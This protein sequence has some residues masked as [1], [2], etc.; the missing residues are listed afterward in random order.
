MKT[1]ELKQ[2]IEWDNLTH[3]EK[4]IEAQFFQMEEIREEHIYEGRKVEE[5]LWINEEL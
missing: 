4:K 3:E 5:E 2:V 1:K